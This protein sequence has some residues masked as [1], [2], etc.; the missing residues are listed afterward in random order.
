M[1]YAEIIADNPQSRLE[2][3][4]GLSFESW[5]PNDLDCGRARRRKAFHGACRWKADRVSGN[6]RR[7]L[8]LK[9]E[10]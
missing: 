10:L 3:G 6:W 7:R 9:R 4:L 8:A 5:G 2:F 1:K